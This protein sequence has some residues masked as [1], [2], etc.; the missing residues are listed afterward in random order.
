M[1][2]KQEKK[3]TCEH[4]LDDVAADEE[5]LFF[6]AKCDPSRIYEEIID[7]IVWD[8][9]TTG[10]VAPK[11]KI[12]EIGCHIVYTNGKVVEKNWVLNNN[13]EIPEK[14]I[15][16]TGI[17]L[18]I[19]NAE[20]RDPEECLREFLPLFKKCKKNITHNGIK[21][22]IPFLVEYASDL[23]RWNEMQKMQVYNL[24]W[25]SAHDTAVAFKSSNLG[26]YQEPRESHVQFANRVMNVRAPLKFNLGVVSDFYQIDR[27]NV[28]QHRAMGDVYL[29]HE[30]FKK[31]LI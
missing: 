8:L 22:D 10:F 24:L 18:D 31:S 7:Y 19:I 29:T 3:I 23:L 2:K 25:E 28:K 12:L 21:F 11:D 1:P 30:V 15:E 9:E 17:T 5:G 26:M 13:V 20:G 16:I 27:S 6:C 4:S 14:I